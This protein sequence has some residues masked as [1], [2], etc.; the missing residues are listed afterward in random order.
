MK[1]D[2]IV[3]ESSSDEVEM[4]DLFTIDGRA[5]Q[6]PA[7]PPAGLALLYLK[8]YRDHG[9]EIANLSLLEAALGDEAFNALMRSSAEKTHLGQVMKVVAQLTLGGLESDPNSASE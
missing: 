1:F 8:Q 2:P 5:Y 7:S 9:E 4:V 3:I 6:V